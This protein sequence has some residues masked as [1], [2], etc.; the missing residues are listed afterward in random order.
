MASGGLCMKS[1]FLEQAR[2]LL[3]ENSSPEAAEGARRFFKEEVLCYGVKSA[4]VKKI[5][6]TVLAGIKKT[7]SRDEIL[8]ACEELWRSGYLEEGGLACEWT[9]ALRKD[10][11][12]DD[13]KVFERWVGSY[14]GNWASCDTL[15]N[16]S[17]AAFVDMYPEFLPDIK[18][19]A[20]SENRWKRRAAAVTFIVPGRRGDYLADILEIA[21]KLLED[22]DDMVQKGYGW[23]LKAASESHP[24]KVFEF[25][26]ARKD[27]MPRT[28]FRYS[29][30]KMPEQWRA[31]AMKK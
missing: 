4:V 26:M 25:I 14:V 28:A 17:L 24:E 23:M 13:F 11:Q 5:A 7:H 6:K 20:A 9:F 22:G 16:H 12:P 19:W 15:C 1:N 8:A 18:G 10:F 3:L 2:G 27:R 21:E 30:E 29:L 31:E